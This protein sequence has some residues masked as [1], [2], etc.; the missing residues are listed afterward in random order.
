MNNMKKRIFSMLPLALPVALSAADVPKPADKP[1]IVII[2]A[3]D[4]GYGDVGCYGAKLIPTPNMDRMAAD[5]LRFTSGYATSAT[6]TPSRYALLTGQYPWRIGATILS[7]EAAMIIRPGT[8]TTASLLKNAGYRTAAIGK[9]H[10]GLGDGR[11]NWN[12]PIHP[13]PNDVGF[14]YSFIMAA[15]MDR[16]P[17]VYLRNGSVVGLDS[18]DPLEVSYKTPFPGMP[19][20]RTTPE[21]VR[22]KSAGDQ[23]ND[24]IVNGVPRIGFYKGGASAQWKDEDMA[25]TY[26]S[27]AVKFMEASKG[28]PFF[29]YLA[30]SDP[31]VPRLPNQRFLGT[32]TLGTRGDSIVEFDWCVGEIMKNLQRLGL[33][34]NTLVIVTSDNG[35]VLEDGYADG[36]K[37]KLSGHTPWGPMQGGKYK[38]YEAGTRV[39]MI[40][41]WP[42]HVKQGVSEAMVCQIDFAASF[43]ALTGQSLKSNEAPDSWNVLPALLGQSATGRDYLVTD[44]VR[45]GLS[46]RQGDWKLLGNEVKKGEAP[47]AKMLFNL[48]NDIGETVDLSERNPEQAAALEALLEKVKAQSRTRPD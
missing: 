22:L 16:V 18:S 2:Y 15:T 36:A 46:I 29:L 23:H 19:L 44:S 48:A 35:P 30:Y 21:G 43:A 39:P 17:C 31:H 8:L 4:L 45:N 41:R 5:G 42:G 37:E 1:N 9:W 12:K 38:G 32:T 20:G 33:D 6:C 7:G 40:V 3:D 26:T 27:E 25:D 11:I 24:A 47:K 28:Q 34:Q 13:C 10:L 14:D